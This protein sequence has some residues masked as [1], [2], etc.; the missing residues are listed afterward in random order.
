MASKET[1]LANEIRR[2]V[3]MLTEESIEMANGEHTLFNHVG[4]T[5]TQLISRAKRIGH[6]ASSFT[7]KEA[8]LACVRDYFNDDYAMSK[9]IKW[10]MDSA[11]PC[12]SDINEGCLFDEII[13]KVALPD[14]TITESSTYSLILQ[15]E[16]KYYRNRIT[17][18]PFDIVTAYVVEE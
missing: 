14:G 2:K 13:G 18:L 4:L 11:T 10:I 9:I 5:D 1:M 6:E 8:V 12:R 17:G 15:K 7:S 16:D 3:N